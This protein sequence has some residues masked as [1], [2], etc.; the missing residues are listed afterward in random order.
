MYSF[1]L[2]SGCSS[3]RDVNPRPLS[4]QSSTLP[5]E[6]PG[7][8]FSRVICV[9]SDSYLCCC[10]CFNQNAGGSIS[11]TKR[12]Q[13]QT[14]GSLLHICDLFPLSSLPQSH[15]VLF[16]LFFCSWAPVILHLLA[17]VLRKV[18]ITVNFDSF[19]QMHCQRRKARLMMSLLQCL[20][21]LLWWV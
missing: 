15:V 10:C 7:K 18:E 9:I 1:T 14:S 17:Q 21:H 2:D 13:N 8:Y 20:K 12:T 5:T 11:A 6:L 3:S 4:H 19:L 16:F